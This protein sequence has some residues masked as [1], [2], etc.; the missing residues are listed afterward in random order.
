MCLQVSELILPFLYFLERK[1]RICLPK[2]KE[3][4]KM[5]WVTWIHLTLQVA[6]PNSVIINKIKC[7]PVSPSVICIAELFGI[8]NLLVSPTIVCLLDQVFVM[9]ETDLNIY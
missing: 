5:F 6:D 7:F 2:F 9:H 8:C 3:G 4:L 1:L